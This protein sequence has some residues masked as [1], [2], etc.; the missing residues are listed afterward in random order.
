MT[1]TWNDP[2]RERPYAGM[3][4]DV[5]AHAAMWLPDPPERSISRAD[6]AQV[7]ILSI[8]ALTI[9]SLVIP[10]D[11]YL[12][13]W[14]FGDP[15]SVL[16]NPMVISSLVTLSAILAVPVIPL[17]L[18]AILLHLRHAAIGRRQGSAD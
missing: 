6:R 4:Q 14:L 5:R 9:F 11:L 13:N 12:A 10:S 17:A 16:H 7:V 1:P 2:T 18:L 3:P 15:I 8:L